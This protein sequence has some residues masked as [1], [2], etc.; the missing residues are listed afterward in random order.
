MTELFEPIAPEFGFSTQGLPRTRG[1][2]SCRPADCGSNAPA[3]EKHVGGA[4]SAARPLRAV[5]LGPCFARGGSEQQ[6]ID[7][8][9]FLDPNRLTIERCIVTERLLIDQAVVADMP[10]PV[11]VG[12]AEAIRR[13]AA[14]H[15]VVLAWGLK[16]DPLLG[17]CRP[18]LCI[19]IAHGDKDWTRGLLAGSV[20]SVDHVVA[21]SKRVREGVCAGFP[22]TVIPNGVDTSRLG[23]TCSR[24]EARRR[25]GFGRSDFVLGYV[26]RFS[27]EKRVERIVRAVARLPDCFKALLV[28]WG[29][30]RSRLIELATQLMPGRFAFANVRR[31][32][33][34]VYQAMDAL[35][36]VSEYEGFGLVVLEAMMCGR[37]VIA[38]PVGNVEEMI[39]DRVNGLIVDGGIDSICRA[40]LMLRR[41]PHWARAIAR[42]GR[43]FAERH[44]HAERMAR[45]YESLIARLWQQK[46]GSRPIGRQ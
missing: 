2:E 28:G 8:A 7:L 44:G 45:D 27:A 31:Y 17:N 15:D 32:L 22:T 40:A 5:H 38:T 37:P 3:D 39:V 6:L 10:A 1:D 36:L 25:L 46:H 12:D 26:G 21:V 20:R 43:R 33:G 41:Y 34:D 11:Q 13:A 9:R 4:A 18:P 35:C 19:F 16:L 24:S 30:D 29:P 42:E 23:R 14:E